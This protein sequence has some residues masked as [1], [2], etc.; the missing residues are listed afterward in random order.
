MLPTG[1]TIRL[2]T[3]EDA[4]PWRRWV[5]EPETLQWFPMQ[6]AAEI[7]DAAQHIFNN[8]RYHA[9]LAAEHEGQPCGIGNLYLPA[10][11][12]VAHQCSLSLLV[13]SGHRGIGVGGALLAGLISI[14]KE[15]F[16]MEQ[17]TLEVYEGNPAIALYRRFG[18]VEYGFQSR[19]VNVDGRYLGKHLMLRWL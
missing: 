6:N 2:A 19:A 16:H 8:V 10:Y 17:L 3:E 7:A 13:A 11:K 4:G 9:V 5:R 18:F 1:Y 15:A 12:R 14:A